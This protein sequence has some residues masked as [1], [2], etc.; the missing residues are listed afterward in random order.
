[1]SEKKKILVITTGDGLLEKIL[2]KIFAEEVEF[3]DVVYVTERNQSEAF[4]TAINQGKPNLIIMEIMMPDIKGGL[5]TCLEM[6][7]SYPSLPFLMLTVAKDAPADMV[8]ELDTTCGES[9]LSDPIPIKDLGL[10]IAQIF[11]RQDI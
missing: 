6:R 4:R 3:Y 2:A 8:Q 10:Q 5:M 1:M 7:D 9:F 11:F